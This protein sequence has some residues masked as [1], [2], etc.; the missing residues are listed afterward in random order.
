MTQTFFFYPHILDNLL[1]PEKGFDVYQDIGDNRLRLYVTSRGVKTFF[2]RKRVHGKDVRVVIGNYPSMTIDDARMELKNTLIKLSAPSPRKKRIQFSRAFKIFASDKI[3]RKQQSMQKLWRSAEKVWMPLW[4]K[5]MNEITTEEIS[6]LNID[7][8]ENHGVPTANRMREIMKSLFAYGYFKG[9]VSENPVLGINPIPEQ[10]RQSN[11]TMAGL[12]K[13]L[14]KIKKE[15]DTVLRDCFLMLVFGFM[16]KSDV[17]AMKWDDID[18]KHDFYKKTPLTDR[19]VVLLQSI[20]QTGIWVF[21][22]K[23]GGHITDPRVSWN[24]IIKS[25]G[26]ED[27]QIND[28][29]K[30]LARQL[31][32]SNLPEALRNNMNKVIEKLA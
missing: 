1:P 29:T 28:V 2:T 31:K 23:R 32:W 17:F 6:K 18:L 4:Q 5:Y 12:G 19:A 8:A 14:A 20:P 9:W 15:K 11:L 16:K 30:L 22:N 27:V 10:R 7:I 26:L 25:A 24:K 13:I 21:P 3:H